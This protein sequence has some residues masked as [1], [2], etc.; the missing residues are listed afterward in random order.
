MRHNIID[1]YSPDGGYYECRTCTHREASEDR[2][3][4]CPACGA[5]VRNIAVPRE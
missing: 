3:M 5:D 2:L 4:A 1:P